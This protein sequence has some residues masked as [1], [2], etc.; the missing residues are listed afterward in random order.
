MRPGLRPRSAGHGPG[1]LRPRSRRRSTLNLCVD[2]EEATGLLVE[3]TLAW[4]HPT[5]DA[6]TAHLTE[7]LSRRS[8]V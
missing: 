8:G 2:I 6:I 1:P 5:I 4:D 3:P 7:L